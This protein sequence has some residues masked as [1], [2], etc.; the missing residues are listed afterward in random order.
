MLSS[1]SRCPRGEP[2]REAVG[3]PRV[4]PGPGPGAVGAP[5]GEPGP[6]LGAV[7]AP[8]G[9]PVP[10]TVGPSRGEP[11]PGPGA[12]GAPRGKP[13]LGP[14]PGQGPGPRGRCR[15]RGSGSPRRPPGSARWPRARAP[16]LT[17][18][19]EEAALIGSRGEPIGGGEA[20]AC[21]R[22]RPMGRRL[23]G[24]QGAGGG[25]GRSGG[26]ERSAGVGSV[27]PRSRRLVT[28]AFAGYGRRAGPGAAGEGRSAPRSPAF[29]RGSSWG[30]GWDPRRSRWAMAGGGSGRGSRWC[31][32]HAGG[33]ARVG[34]GPGGPGNDPRGPLCEGP[35]TPCRSGAAA[36]AG[37]GKVKLSLHSARR[38]RAGL[39][40]ARDDDTGSVP[41]GGESSLLGEV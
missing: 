29:G 21:P 2:G 39:G 4:E 26:A 24:R 25:G 9:E 8:W 5:R 27:S 12:V 14:G 1:G 10:G 16:P 41:V 20:G 37:A 19:D 28:P 35:S 15:A 32:S 13:G 3:A 36:A 17:S 22:S 18:P 23:G 31:R 40:L 34:V 38:G 30:P 7:G 6:A 33:A 11:G